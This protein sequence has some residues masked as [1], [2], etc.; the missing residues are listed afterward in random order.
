MNLSLKNDRLQ[1][2][3]NLS[4]LG[5]K[6]IRRFRDY[7][8]NTFTTTADRM[9]Q[10]AIDKLEKIADDEDVSW[11]HFRQ[12]ARKLLAP[13]RK[14]FKN[15]FERIK[16]AVEAMAVAAEAVFDLLEDLGSRI[17]NAVAR[18]RDWLLSLF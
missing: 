1:Y 14:A 16:D 4:G 7:T 2:Y 13:V 10:S 9:A 17:A 18:F 12:I 11:T 15:A 8:Q 6:R 3:S 5:T